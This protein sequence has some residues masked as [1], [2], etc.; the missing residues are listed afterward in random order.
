LELMVI[1]ASLL[2]DCFTVGRNSKLLFFVF[3]QLSLF[4]K[5]QFTIKKHSNSVL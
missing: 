3:F 5:H 4:F 2:L 1:Q